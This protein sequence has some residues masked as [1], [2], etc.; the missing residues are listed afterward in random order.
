MGKTKGNQTRVYLKRWCNRSINR[1]QKIYEY[2]LRI[3]SNAVRYNKEEVI[4][5][6]KTVM[7]VLDMLVEE[8]ERLRDYF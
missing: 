5:Q 6:V 7:H 1:L 8:L 4:S 2:M 3:Y